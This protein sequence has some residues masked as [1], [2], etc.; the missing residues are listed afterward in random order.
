M[1]IGNNTWPSVNL[2]EVCEFRYGRSLPEASRKLGEHPVF[3]SNGQVGLHNEALTNG[4][5]II[6]GRKG[7]IGEVSYSLDSCWPIDTTYFIDKSCTQQDIRW[8]AHA[9]VHLRLTELNKSAAIPGLNRED[10][11]RQ[12]LL[13]PPFVEQRRIAAILDRVQDVRRERQ[14]T[15]ERLDAFA[16]A[17]LYEFWA[18]SRMRVKTSSLQ[19]I[20]EA[21]RHTFGNGPFGSDLLTEE[22]REEG[23]PVIYIRDIREGEYRRVSKSCVTPAKARVLQYCSVKSG[24]ILIAKVGDPPGVAA[25]YPFTLLESQMLL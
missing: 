18:Q 17:L 23:V 14:R 15:L 25:I 9:L 2:G 6:I 16:N 12:R 19:E 13:L 22:L 8:L 4:E 1:S 10:A 7:S 20:A 5:T 21:G 3:G 24:D 11:Y